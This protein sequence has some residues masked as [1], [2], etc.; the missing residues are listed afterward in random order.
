M[1]FEK[2][3]RVTQNIGDHLYYLC[4]EYECG[5]SAIELQGGN[6]ILLYQLYFCLII[7]LPIDGFTKAEQMDSVELS[8]FFFCNNLMKSIYS[9]SPNDNFE[10]NMTL[11]PDSY[12]WPDFIVS[13]TFVNSPFNLHIHDISLSYGGNENM[14]QNLVLFLYIL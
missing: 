1:Y 5:I 12:S 6:W 11:Q 14:F 7:L 10:W 9:L 3:S 4:M 2:C 8:L 13:L